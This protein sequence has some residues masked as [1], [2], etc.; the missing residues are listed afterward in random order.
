[1]TAELLL[2]DD[3]RRIRHRLVMPIDRSLPIDKTIMAGFTDVFT[4]R[5]AEST[6]SAACASC[7]AEEQRIWAGSAHARALERLPVV[8][9]TDGCV[10][11][12]S[13]V[14][15]APVERSGGVHCQSCHQGAD[16]HAAG[17]TAVK[18]TGV[19]D[20]RS[21]HDP[22][23]DPGFDPVADWLRIRHGRSATAP[24]LS[25]PLHPA[26]SGPPASP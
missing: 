12:H 11:C 19:T 20:C 2:L 17:G 24:S 9:R 14:V 26:H 23:H 7:H 8:D 25:A 18:T 10:G 16:A 21:C 15:N 5:W 6:P 4:G 1:M 22:R 13:L 3:Q